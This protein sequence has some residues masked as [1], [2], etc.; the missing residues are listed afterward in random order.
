MSQSNQEQQTARRFQPIDTEHSYGCELPDDVRAQLVS[1]RRPRILTPPL[2]V[3]TTH[4]QWPFYV[5]LTFCLV[6]LG[7]AVTTLWRQQERERASSTKA[8]SQPLTPQP[9]PAPTPVT[10]PPGNASRPRDHLVN[11]SPAPRATRPARYAG[12]IAVTTSPASQRRAALGCRPA[13]PG[14]HTL[15]NRASLGSC[16][17]RLFWAIGVT[18]VGSLV[19]PE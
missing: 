15:R 8:I 1:P 16:P 18:Y 9:T 7:G 13:L 2:S 6:A 12:E 17:I 3:S 5:I 4:P 11:N 10:L 19:P 14:D